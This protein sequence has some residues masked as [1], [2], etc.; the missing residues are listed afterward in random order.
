MKRLA[1]FLGVL[2]VICYTGPVICGGL[3]L[4]LAMAGVAA[5]SAVVVGF[6]ATVSI[7]VATIANAI[8]RNLR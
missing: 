2:L 4:L 8:W 7:F 5:S 3:A 1:A 6:F